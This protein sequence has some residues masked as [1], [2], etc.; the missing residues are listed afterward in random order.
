VIGAQQTLYK[1]YKMATLVEKVCTIVQISEDEIELV[2][3]HEDWLDNEQLM[4]V[5]K[6]KLGHHCSQH[7][8]TSNMSKKRTTIE[9][10]IVEPEDGPSRR[11]YSAR[12]R[13]LLQEKV[14]K[15]RVKMEQQSQ[16]R[17]ILLQKLQ[18]LRAEMEQHGDGMKCKTNCGRKKDDSSTKEK[19][20]DLFD[21]IRRTVVGITGGVLTVA[22]VALIPCPMIPGLLVV[23]LGLVTLATEFDSAKNALDMFQGKFMMLADYAEKD[24]SV[25]SPGEKQ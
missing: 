23:Y 3:S 7:Y 22:G 11:R 10:I 12:E 14:Q 18:N 5:I 19:E 8:N 16:E 9:A 25:A 17:K 6:K 4:D 1:R 2:E 15:L 24:I 13:K 20:E 21:H